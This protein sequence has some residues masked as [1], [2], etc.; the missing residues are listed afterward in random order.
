MK[1]KNCL[2][3]GASGQIGRHLIRKLTKNNYKVTA[4]TRNLHQKGYIL[5]TQASAGWIDCVETDIF[6]E[7]KLRK[8]ISKATICINLIGVLF[9]ENKFNSFKNIHTFFPLLLSKICKEYNIKQL[10]HLSALGIELN[11]QP[12]DSKYAKSKFYGEINVKNNFSKAIILR[13]SIVYSVDDKL[14]TQ[15][16]TLL[17]RLPVFPLFGNPKFTPIHVKDL[18]EIIYQIINKEINSQTIECI[19]KEILSFKDILQK[20]LY[21]IDKK[22]FIIS[23]PLFVSKLIAV[24]FKI[25]PKPLITID[26]IKL[27]NACDNVSSGKYKTNFDIGIPSLCNFEEEVEKYC[28]MWKDAGQFSKKNIIKLW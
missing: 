8:L 24:S 5:K 22:R 1:P 2:I 15:F 11:D 27:L 28:Y 13:P 7:K 20:L 6:D 10:I 19:G 16:M 26:Q 9:E 3:F 17:N 12:V 23:L 18:T 21:L 4:V 25:L 14:T